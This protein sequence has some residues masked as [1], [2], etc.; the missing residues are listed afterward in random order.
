MMGSATKQ[1]LVLGLWGVRYQVKDV[2]RSISFY[3]ETLGFN[4]DRQNLPAFGQVSIG[5]LKLIALAN[6]RSREC[7][8][9]MK[10]KPVPAAS[11]FRW[12]TRTA[13]R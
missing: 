8:F 13:I 2:Q 4:L 12:R 10:W 9:A 6:S 1:P 3:T 5:D 7:A 11:R